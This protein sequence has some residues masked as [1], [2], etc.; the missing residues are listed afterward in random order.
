[1]AYQKISEDSTVQKAYVSMRKK[2]TSHSIAEICATQQSPGLQTDT[3]FLI[4]KDQNGFY[5]RQLQK[6]VGRSG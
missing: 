1:M 4:G 6:W 3:R 2:G 5:S